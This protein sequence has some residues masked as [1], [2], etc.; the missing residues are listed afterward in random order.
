MDMLGID[1]GTVSIKYVRVR[2]KGQKAAVVSKGIYPYGGELLQLESVLSDIR[3]K[4]GRLRVAIGISSQDIL[5]KSVTIPVLPKEEIADALDWSVSKTVSLPLNEMSY[6]YIML[7]EVEERGIKKEEACFVGVQR[8]FVDGLLDSFRKSGFGDVALLTDIGLVYQE[9]L[10]EERT[11]STSVVDVGGTQTGIYVFEKGKIKLVR[12][13][14]IAAESFSDALI[15]GLA[16]HPMGAESSLDEMFR[17]GTV[18]LSESSFEHFAE[19]IRRT[20]NV[21]EKRYPG[22]AVKKIY[23]AGRGSEIPTFI[24]RLK[25]R[26]GEGVERLRPQRDIEPQYLPAFLLACQREARVNL[27]PEDI[28]AGEREAV[29]RKWLTMGTIAVAAVLLFLSLDMMAAQNRLDMAVSTEA[30][31]VARLKEQVQVLGRATSTGKYSDMIPLMKE[32]RRKDETFVTLLKYLSSHLPKEVYL[33]EIAFGQEIPVLPAS[34]S[35]GKG[36]TPTEPVQTITTQAGMRP[37]AAK[38]ATKPGAPV[39]VENDR[40]ITITGLVFGEVDTADPAL[41]DFIVKLGNTGIVRDVEVAGKQVKV[42]KGKRVIEFVVTG[43]CAPYE[44]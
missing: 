29:Y 26:F 25:E 5:K 35:S 3:T 31:N 14:L 12:E 43:K 17:K 24:E 40:W 15:S 30:A 20:L 33:R 39:V 22:E 16:L 34:G 8:S 27:L 10:K 18:E 1:I 13:I 9:V 6:E 41:L 28:K 23:V 38:P 36:A 42:M 32:I 7:G 2:G 11:V 44:I 19:E 37:A 21:F 4:E